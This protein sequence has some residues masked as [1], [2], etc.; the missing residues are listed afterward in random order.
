MLFRSRCNDEKLEYTDNFIYLGIMLNE[1][2]DYNLTAKF[3]SQAAG[4]ALGLLIAKFKSIGGMPFTVYTKL[5]DSFVWSGI[6]YG[7]AVWGTRQFTCID[8]IQIVLCVFTIGQVD[9]HQ[10]LLL[11]V[12]WAGSQLVLGN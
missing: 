10:I 11:P 5:Y 6:S 4:R 12:T 3:V 8:A 2:L 7:A 9:I 1:Y